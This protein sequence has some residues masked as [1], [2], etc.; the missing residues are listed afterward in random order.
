[1]A[2]PIKHSDIAW[3]YWKMDNIDASK[4]SD[5][6]INGN[7]LDAIGA[8]TTV[9]D[10]F[11]NNAVRVTGTPTGVAINY[12]RKDNIL[13][14]NS[15]FTMSGWFK[16]EPYTGSSYETYISSITTH[17]A[18][19][20]GIAVSDGKKYS[21]NYFDGSNHVQRE[22]SVTVVNDWVH[23]ALVKN[24][25]QIKLFVNGILEV[26]DNITHNVGL[27]YL[28][29]Y[30]NSGMISRITYAVDELLIW[31]ESLS[32]S[33]VQEVYSSYFP[34]RKV[35]VVN[36]GK[37]IKYDSDNQSWVTV[38][39][40]EP[41]V[42]SFMNGNNH[43][44]IESIPESAWEQ[45]NGIVETRYYVEDTDKK[46]VEFNLETNPFTLKEELG[47]IFSII[48]Y[49]DSPSQETSAITLETEPFSV[50]DYIGELPTV[51]AY[52]ESTEDIIV[53]T[54][55]EPFDV[56]DEF[57]DT[58][59]VLYYTDDE[60]VTS[61]DLIIDANWSPIDE[62][63]GDFEV[64]TWTDEA[65]ENAQRVF[66]MR[67]T[68][69]PQFTYPIDI[70][71]IRNGVLGLSVQEL[72]LPLGSNKAR[73]LL[74][75]DNE[76]W[77]TWQKNS[78]V[79]IMLSNENILEQGMTSQQL[80]RLTEEDL[81]KWSLSTI[82]VGVFL[83]DDIRG[84]YQ[85]K[86]SEV[87]IETELNTGTP[88]VEEASFYILNTTATINVDFSGLTLTGQ[89]DDADMTR[90]QYRVILNGQPYFPSSGNFTPLSS[91][92][93]NIDITLRSADVK[94]GDWNTIRVEFQD[95]FGSMDYWEGQFIGKYA[96]LM[97]MDT[98]GNYYSTD[99]GQ[100]LQYLDFGEML[101]GQIS[102][103]YEIKVR[104]DYGFNVKNTTIKVNKNHFAQGLTV[105]LSNKNR[106]FATEELQIGDLADGAETTFFI[107]ML[108]DVNTIPNN[109]SQFDIVV[110]AERA[111]N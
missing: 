51:I 61:A 79:P 62:L 99:V 83:E 19:G 13:V 108:S 16:V 67:A 66:E 49:T 23:L 37:C 88:V 12:L 38:T 100:V 55:T 96:G 20:V 64:V 58:V 80:N 31:R 24:G 15:N 56:Y 104:N 53:S 106:D 26:T 91:P 34:A 69:K 57:N 84:K 105:Q 73:F 36:D 41:T 97:F 63:E 18:N 81:S 60:A 102:P 2:K 89:V 45:L 3:S 75:P 90:V 33:Q 4:V 32:D 94:I 17:G 42:E 5:S 7:V 11:I 92:P 95:Y 70:K 47:N 98:E 93:L 54:T 46:E 107:R 68:P 6:T 103:S 76:R 86:I 44:E 109:N 74:T 9:V 77:Y 87:N 25:S 59:E 101:T 110:M 82:N 71:N 65:P 28:S 10:G 39:I 52:T 1:M 22:S 8:G 50:Y 48:E 35:L 40:S 29:C 43:S 21:I 72:S 27:H 30:N 85:S 14:S 78:F 111:I